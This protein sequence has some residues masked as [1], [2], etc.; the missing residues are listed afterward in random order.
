MLPLAAAMR[1][2]ERVD[3][4]DEQARAVSHGMSFAAGALVGA[5][6][7][8]RSRSSTARATLLAV[9]E[10]ARRGIATALVALVA[11]A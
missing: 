6:A 11:D 8:V 7:T 9:Y 4:D 2:L 3:V 10:T 5:R 1:D